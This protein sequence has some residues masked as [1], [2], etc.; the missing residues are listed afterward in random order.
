MNM[1]HKSSTSIVVLRSPPKKNNEAA[2][3]RAWL[4]DF[5]HMTYTRYWCRTWNLAL[6]KISC[7]VE[8][9]RVR[10]AGL[11]KIS[12]QI[13]FVWPIEISSC[14][15]QFNLKGRSNFKWGL[16]GLYMYVHRDIILGYVTGDYNFLVARRG[17]KRHGNWTITD[18]PKCFCHELNSRVIFG[19]LWRSEVWW[20]SWPK[21]KRGMPP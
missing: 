20:N 15:I 5:F 13:L 3:W 1:P 12:P 2:S 6:K 11:R 9:M 7:Q 16:N 21:Q 4:R 18:W 10:D 19:S 8:K 17:K 14:F